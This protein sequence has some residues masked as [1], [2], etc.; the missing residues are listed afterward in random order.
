ME[1]APTE[2]CGI[3]GFACS[4]LVTGLAP[5]RRG[6]IY[7]ARRRVSEANRHA[8]AALRPEIPPAEPRAATNRADIES[9]PTE[10]CNIAGFAC[11][12][13]VTGLAPVRRG[14]IYPARRR[15]SE[16]N[17][18]A[19]AALRP[20][21]PPAEP[22]AATNRADIESAPTEVCNIAG[23][24]CSRLVTG[25][26]PVR[27]GGIYPARGCSRRREAPGTMRASSPTEVCNIAGFAFSR[28]V[29]GL[30]SVR[31]GGIYPARGR[32]RRRNV[33]G[34]MQASS[35]TEVCNIAG[36]ACSRLA[37]GLA[38]VRRGGFHIRPGRL[39][40]RTV[41]RGEGTPPYVRPGGRGCPGWPKT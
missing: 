20:E 3:A 40:R 12:R 25:L 35:P 8:A 27:R 34:T 2:V 16:A 14:G 15:V 33:R 6:G 29:T 17:R 11:S 31:R 37:A 22:R 9:A 13:L 41:R 4:R 5:V 36:F 10:V 30:V 39:C 38:L 18:H 26:A 1:S 21:I 7:P 32:S 23:F 28:L 24:A 19:A